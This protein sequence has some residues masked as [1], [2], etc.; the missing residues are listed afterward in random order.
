MASDRYGRPS[1][2]NAGRRVHSR[3]GLSVAG[4][5]A[6]AKR[7]SDGTGEAGPTKATRGIPVHLRVKRDVQC[8]PRFLMVEICKLH[9]NH[10][11]TKDQV[12]KHECCWFEAK[13][14]PDSPCDE[15]RQSRRSGPPVAQHDVAGLDVRTDRCRTVCGERLCQCCHRECSGSRKSMARSNAIKGV[16]LPEGG[17]GAEVTPRL[18]QASRRP[19]A[20]YRHRGFQEGGG[21]PRT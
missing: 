9:P 15:R 8:H 6:D 18:P 2:F 19:N 21:P 14:V 10:G 20:R 13:L 16:R 12:A 1:F 17:V 11:P 7:T 4:R 3:D 5:R